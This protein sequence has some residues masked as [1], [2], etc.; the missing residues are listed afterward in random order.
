MSNRF[1]I[2]VIALIVLFV[3]GFAFTK[4]RD[5]KEAGNGTTTSAP[6]N[7]V[8]GKDK[9]EVV[10]VEYGDYQCSACYSY[11][12]LVHDVRE[13]YKDRIA[14]QFRNFPIVSSHPNAFV[15]ARA[16]EAAALQNKFW[17]MHDKL[18]ETQDPSGKT[19]WV[20]SSNPTSFFVSFATELGMDADRFQK[21]MNSSEV[22]NLI[23]ADIAEGR[24]VP[25]NGTPTFVLNG[26]KVEQEMRSVEDFYKLLDEALAEKAPKS[27]Q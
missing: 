21:D 10:L 11:E 1:F 15:A 12:P 3:G 22:N 9:A 25:V 20:A 8:Y 13:K 4:Q 27:S 17:E 18:Y 6:T 26:K 24:K 16:A 5:N 23:N 14:F 19:G 2:T 7:H